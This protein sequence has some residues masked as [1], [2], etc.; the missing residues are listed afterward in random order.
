MRSMFRL[1]LS[2]LFVNAAFAA[3]GGDMQLEARLV[4]GTNDQ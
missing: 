4:W 1:M 3:R 2:V